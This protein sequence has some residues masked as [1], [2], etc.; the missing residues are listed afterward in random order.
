MKKFQLRNAA[1]KTLPSLEA[2]VIGF[3]PVGN[4]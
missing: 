1:K 4:L 2:K 3:Y